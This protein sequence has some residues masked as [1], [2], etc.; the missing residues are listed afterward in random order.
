MPVGRKWQ[1]LIHK[2]CPDCD[3]VFEQQ[4]T[5][6]KCM[7]D[8]CGFG[9]S[10]RKM[11]QIL[12]DPTHAARRLLNNQE[13]ELLRDALIECGITNPDDFMPKKR[14]YKSP[15]LPPLRENVV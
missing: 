8:D 9:I 6:F 12:T 1:N 14:E 4:D 15:Y 11:A 10:R 2:K 7:K 5:I 3:S 13:N